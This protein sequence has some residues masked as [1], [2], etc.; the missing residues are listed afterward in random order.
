M[1]FIR[2]LFLFFSSNLAVLSN[3]KQ[4][5][6][7]PW[8]LLS[9]LLQKL[10]KAFF[11]IAYLCAKFV[12]FTHLFLELDCT[13]STL[14]VVVFWEDG[15]W[16][17]L[18]PLCLSLYLCWITAA[19]SLQIDTVNNSVEPS[20]VYRSLYNH[21]HAV[22]LSGNYRCANFLFFIFLYDRFFSL[23]VS[24]HE[25]VHCCIEVFFSGS[26]IFFYGLSKVFVSNPKSGIDW[27]NWILNHLSAIAQGCAYFCCIASLCLVCTQSAP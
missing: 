13:S 7:F 27:M 11:L 3:T 22:R 4:G 24:G 1:C 5:H 21:G 2:L 6:F 20:S 12:A 18:V 19:M 17:C 25:C 14:S 16:L 23:C 9:E 26:C 10:S 15:H 8:S